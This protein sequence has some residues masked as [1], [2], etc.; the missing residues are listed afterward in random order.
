[1]PPYADYLIPA[2]M[3]V[4]EDKIKE[5]G[6]KVRQVKA[7]TVEGVVPVEVASLMALKEELNT[8]ITRLSQTT[9]SSA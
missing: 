1:M 9:L 3:I 4:L 7:G 5:Q 6:E 8:L 2:E